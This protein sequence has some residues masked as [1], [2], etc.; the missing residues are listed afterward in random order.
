MPWYIF[1]FHGILPQNQPYLKLTC[2][3]ITTDAGVQRED[4]IKDLWV[5]RNR[6]V[7]I[8]NRIETLLQSKIPVKP[9][10][11]RARVESFETY[12]VSLG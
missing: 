11:L 3:K 1:R 10:V 9:W 6:T 8:R 12:V 7:K 5:L 2:C 4:L